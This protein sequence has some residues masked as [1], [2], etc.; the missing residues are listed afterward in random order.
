MAD[1][2][3]LYGKPFIVRDTL[4]HREEHL[5]EYLS[6]EERTDEQKIREMIFKFAAQE[7][8]F[9]ITEDAK[10]IHSTNRDIG[11][12]IWMI[13]WLNFRSLV[14]LH[15][16]GSLMQSLQANSNYPINQ[17]LDLHC[18]LGTLFDE[19]LLNT[20][21]N[22]TLRSIQLIPY[23][24]APGKETTDW[25]KIHLETP[26]IW[27]VILLQVIIRSMIVKPQQP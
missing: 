7:K 24:I 21:A 18:R 8:L 22:R 6:E 23:D 14:D 25:D 17:L 13:N 9:D 26:F 19:R 4:A 10:P 3:Y 20:L 12:W 1:N 15:Q 16:Y 5:L 11:S 27:L 2:L